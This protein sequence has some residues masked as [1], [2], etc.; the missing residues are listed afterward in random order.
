MKAKVPEPEEKKKPGKAPRQKP[1]RKAR[2][3]QEKK[4]A[5]PAEGGKG[6]PA[7]RGLFK[8]KDLSGD[9]FDMMTE[10]K[11]PFSFSGFFEEHVAERFRRAKAILQER[12]VIFFLFSPFQAKGRMVAVLGALC[13]GL[14]FGV[15]PRAGALISQTRDR[16]YA[17]EIAGLDSRSVGSIQ[18]VPAASSNYKR[19]HMLAFVIEGKN[20]PS[21]PEKYEVHLS[22]GSGAADWDT[23]TYSWSMYPVDDERRILLVAIDQTKQPSGVGMFRLFIQLAGE[24]L[25]EYAKQPYEVTLSSAQETG[26]LY[27]R[28]GVHLSALT[29][30]ICGSG[31]IEKKQAEFADALEEY[32]MAVEQAEKMPVDDIQVS[33][34]PEDLE[35]YCLSKRL[36]RPLKDSSTT[37]DI[38]K[39]EKA[40]KP[41][42]SIGTVISCGGVDGGE[43][44]DAFIAEL[45]GM[46]EAGRELTDGQR[47]IFDEW[48]HV[49]AAKGKVLAAMDSVNAAAESWYNTLSGY[50]LILNQTVKVGS[51]PLYARI[52][53]T[54]E[55]PISWIDGSPEEPGDEPGGIT[56]T[57]SGEDEGDVPGPEATGRPEGPDPTPGPVPD[58][59][60]DPTPEP[61]PD[62]TPEPTPEPTDG[63]GDGAET[64]PSAY[65]PNPDVTGSPLDN[66]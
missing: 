31:E 61:V 24:E 45:K 3:E 19:M 10:M 11:E 38:L 56:G 37:E 65:S 66:K 16:A 47:K 34:S 25:K 6:K 20:L 46:E 8:K 54:I 53:D 55:S 44:D 60:P 18:V 33:P 43:Y 17:S 42:L 14:M 5:G 40:E 1:D 28:T 35:T 26:P 57:V 13:M 21:D 4:P 22:Q 48:D 59:T 41:K 9:G 7:F 15:V 62:P 52:T 49:D 29:E 39:I 36:Y 2:Q 12:G 23:L 63:E 30:A 58:P 32:R 51:F 50:R 64:E 27:D